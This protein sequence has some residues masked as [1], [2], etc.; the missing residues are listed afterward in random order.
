MNT[1]QNANR[2]RQLN[3]GDIT[4]RK[5]REQVK[6]L[7]ENRDAIA[8][9]TEEFK[10]GALVKVYIGGMPY[11]VSRTVYNHFFQPVDQGPQPGDDGVIDLS[12]MYD[13]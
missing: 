13:F 5:Y 10:Q 12:G 8:N 1:L 9:S 4:G 3:H 7:S 11:A 6:N 2:P